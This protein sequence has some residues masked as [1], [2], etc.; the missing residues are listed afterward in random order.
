SNN[1]FQQERDAQ[2]SGKVYNDLNGNGSFDSGEPTMAE[3]P[4]SL[5]DGTPDP[6]A[7][8][9]TDLNGAFSFTGLPKGDYS[10][11]YTVSSGF[12]NTGTR[13]I[14]VH[15]PY[16]ALFRSSNNFFQQERDAQISGKVYNDLNGNGSF[17]SGEP[18]M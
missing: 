12:V 17:D 13:P 5:P 7:N 8:T 14:A 15:Y 3:V 9:S 11:S 18:T 2:I 4:V 1:F 10:V 6:P 16:A